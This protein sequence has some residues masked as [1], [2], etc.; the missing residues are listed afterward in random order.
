MI[1]PPG[2][3]ST[4]RYLPPPNTWTYRPLERTGKI[5][6]ISDIHDIVEAALRSARVDIESDEDARSVRVVAPRAITW[7]RAAR[8]KG[9][10]ESSAEPLFRARINV[11]TPEASRRAQSPSVETNHDS[12][13]SLDWIRGRDRNLVD[14][15]WAFLVRKIGDAVRAT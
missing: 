4:A 3:P 13:I 9:P 10:G 2:F 1:R 5:L 11:A 6:H 14:G 15:F 12:V 7:T 8:R